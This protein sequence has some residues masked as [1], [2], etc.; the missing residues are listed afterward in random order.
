MTEAAP[1][2]AATTIK[3]TPRWL[4]AAR[5]LKQRHMSAMLLLAFAAGIP[6]GA[7]LGT[8]NAWLTEAGIKPATIGVLSFITLAYAYKFLWAPAFQ[9]PLFLWPTRFGPRRAWLLAFQ[10]LIVIL[11]FWLAFSNPNSALSVMAGLALLIS[12]A[13]AT[14]DIVLDAWRLEVAESPEDLDLMAA[15]YQFGYRLAGLATGLGALLLSS[16]IGWEATYFVLSATMA[17][18]MVGVWLAPEPRSSNPLHQ[19]ATRPSYAPRITPTEQIWAVGIVL[20]AWGA[21]IALIGQFMWQGL[22]AAEPP[23]GA[24]FIRNQG[25]IIIA[26]CVLVPALCASWLLFQRTGVSKPAHSNTLSPLA[27]GTEDASLPASSTQTPSWVL[28]CFQSILDPL[29]DLVD[30]LRW[31]AILVLALVLCYRFT[32]HVWGAFAFPFYLGKEFGAIGHTADE[33]AFA[34]KTFGVFMTIA[35][36]AFGA[37]ALV[38]IGRLPCLILGAIIAAVTNLLYADLSLGGASLDAFLGATGLDGLYASAGADPRMAR[39][40]TTIAGENIAGGFASVAFVAYMSAIVNPRFAAVQYALLAS[41]TMLIG[42][43]GRAPLGDMIEIEGYAAVFTLTFWLGL[44]AVGL[45]VLEAW[46]QNKSQSEP[47]ESIAPS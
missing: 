11:L 9:K 44:I 38:F 47:K 31:S 34:S 39:L 36:S 6:Y 2:T 1:Q 28:T 12:L 16:R 10:V 22:T 23:S 29:M 30:R 13:S 8:L 4:K 41:L 24:G 37:A 35:G 15:L 7:V 14:H 3:P 46:R 26:L 45:S 20:A 40:L 18:A 17:L 27:A 32:D 43:L 5:A 21:A 19:S 33:I 25:P 42:T